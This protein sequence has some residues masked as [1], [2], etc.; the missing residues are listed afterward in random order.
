MRSHTDNRNISIGLSESKDHVAGGELKQMNLNDLNGYLEKARFPG[1]LVS[2]GGVVLVRYM[3]Y[4]APYKTLSVLPLVQ[5][6]SLISPCCTSC[7]KHYDG[8]EARTYEPQSLLSEPSRLNELL[9][10]LTASLDFLCMA[11][12][13]TAKEYNL[14][15]SDAYFLEKILCAKQHLWSVLL[16]DAGH[17]SLRTLRL[18]SR[19]MQSTTVLRQIYLNDGSGNRKLVGFNI[20]YSSIGGAHYIFWR[21]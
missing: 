16:M 19:W 7:T 10:S 9:W 5:L 21:E 17:P 2:G 18:I 13:G 15:L 20:Q 14:E 4:Q 11:F 8:T 6:L 3:S 12:R 1:S